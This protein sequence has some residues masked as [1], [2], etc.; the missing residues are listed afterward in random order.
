MCEGV[1]ALD[2]LPSL[3][4]HIIEISADACVGARLSVPH[5]DFIKDFADT[6]INMIYEG[7]KG[8]E[9]IGPT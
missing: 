1:L 2:A 6:V 7:A 5:D 3:R 4:A 9:K 8:D